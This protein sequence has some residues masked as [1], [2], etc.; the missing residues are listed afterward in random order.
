VAEAFIENPNDVL[1]C[2]YFRQRT[3]RSW[4]NGKD[5]DDDDEQERWLQYCCSCRQS[6]ASVVSCEW[7]THVHCGRARSLSLPL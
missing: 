6:R 1:T 5:D 7:T 4:R 2:M 3:R